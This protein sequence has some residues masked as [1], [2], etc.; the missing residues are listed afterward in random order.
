MQEQG[1]DMLGGSNHE[2]V[3]VVPDGPFKREPEK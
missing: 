3:G 1:M 2:S